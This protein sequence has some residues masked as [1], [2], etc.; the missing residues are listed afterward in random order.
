MKVKNSSLW[1]D[2][3]LFLFSVLKKMFYLQRIDVLEHWSSR[4][5]KCN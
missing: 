5:D 1:S 3:G 2:I 4:G